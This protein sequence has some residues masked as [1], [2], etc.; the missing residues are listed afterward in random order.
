[1][2]GEKTEKKS[3]S[4]RISLEDFKARVIALAEK[5]MT[6]EDIGE[7]LRSQGI[8]PQEYGKISRILKEKGLYQPPEIRN[9]Q[10]KLER[11]TAHKEKN[12][13]DKRAMRERERFFS[14]LRKQKEYHKLI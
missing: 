13:Q 12:I 7:A 8:H 2:P 1:M 4:E 11:V 10:E 6:S 5:G 3:I 14:L 9:I